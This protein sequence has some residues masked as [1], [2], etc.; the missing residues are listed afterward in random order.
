M[1]EEIIKKM[2]NNGWNEQSANEAYLFLVEEFQ[3]IIEDILKPIDLR[4]Y[5]DIQGN[6]TVVLKNQK[7]KSFIIQEIKKI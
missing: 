2:I 5:V 7:I 3:K 4:D 6:A 1:K